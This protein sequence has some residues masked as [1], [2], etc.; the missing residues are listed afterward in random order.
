MKKSHSSVIVQGEVSLVATVLVYV[1]GKLFLLSEPQFTH[2]Y[3]TEGYHIFTGSGL[4]FSIAALTCAEV[5]QPP[6]TPTSGRHYTFLAT[7]N[8]STSVL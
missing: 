3:L 5:S 6:S 7:F 1:M 8:H 4:M 2:P